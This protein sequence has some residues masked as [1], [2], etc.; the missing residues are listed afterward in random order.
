[1]NP[2]G[3]EVREL[4][5]KGRIVDAKNIPGGYVV[6]IQPAPS[7]AEGTKLDSKAAKLLKM[8]DRE[9]VGIVFTGSQELPQT[10]YVDLRFRVAGKV[11]SLVEKALSAN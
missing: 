7:F 11:A 1:M 10:G 6:S 9:I 3:A 8:Q 5:H 2:T 4:T